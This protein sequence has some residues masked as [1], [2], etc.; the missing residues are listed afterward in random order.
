VNL[1]AQLNKLAR[2]TGIVGWLSII[3]GAFSAA[4]GLFAYAVR[5]WINQ[6]RLKPMWGSFAYVIAGAISGVITVILGIKLLSVRKHA[7]NIS[8]GLEENADPDMNDMVREL[9]LYFEIQGILQIIGVVVGVLT[10]IIVF[11]ALL[12]AGM[13]IMNYTDFGL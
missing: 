7:L 2:W 9:A 11:V 5:T 8:P 1:K 6:V 10:L 3:G 4:A 13:S 12:T